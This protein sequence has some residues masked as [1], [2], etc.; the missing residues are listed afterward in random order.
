MLNDY[1]QRKIQ[2]PTEVIGKL[3]AIECSMGYA[4][5]FMQRISEE[6]FEILRGAQLD[7]NIDFRLVK[8]RIFL[9]ITRRY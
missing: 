9:E 2:Y 5:E 7:F 3:E 1:I 8:K 6:T 4:F